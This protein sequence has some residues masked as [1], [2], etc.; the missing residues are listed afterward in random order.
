MRYTKTAELLR[1]HGKLAVVSTHHVLL[2]DGDPFF[3]GV[4]EDYEAVVPDDP[5]ARADAGGPPHPDASLTGA[6]RSPEAAGS[7]PSSRGATSGT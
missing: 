4:Q 1:E 7:A 2:P 5:E 6:R 3:V